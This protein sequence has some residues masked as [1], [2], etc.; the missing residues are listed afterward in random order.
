VHKFRVPCHLGDDFFIMVLSIINAM[1]LFLHTKVNIN[2]HSPSR[3]H[4]VTEGHRSFQNCGSSLQNLLHAT[5]LDPTVWTWPNTVDK[6]VD[7]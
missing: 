5:V 6:F 3:K 1:F 2:S 7:P 4:Q